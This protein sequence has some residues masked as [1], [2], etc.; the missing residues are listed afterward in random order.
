MRFQERFLPYVLAIASSAIALLLKLSLEPILLHTI[1]EFFYIAIVITAWYSGGRA[2]FVTLVLATLAINYFFLPPIYKFG[3]VQPIDLVQLGIF[4]LVG[5]TVNLVSSNFRDSKRKI[6]QL[7]QQLIQEKAD[8]LRIAPLAAQMGMWNWDIVTGKNQWSPDQEQL[9]GL[10]PGT[11]DG[12]YETFLSYIHPED[13]ERVNQ[14]LQQ[15]IQNHS[16]Y[17]AEFRI[18]WAD[19]S[20]HWIEARGHAFYNQAGE[21]IQMTGTAT[22]IDQR[23][24]AQGLLQDKF[25]Q[26][27]LVMEVTQRIRQSLNLQDIFQNTVDEIRQL[28]QTDRVI[29]FQFDPQWRGT[30]VA[31]SVGTDWTATLSTEIYNPCFSEQYVEPYKQGLVTVKSDIYNVGID[32][33]HLQ[34]LANFQV[35]ANLVVPIVKEGELWGLL[36]AHHCAAPR[37]WQSSEINLMQQ[38]ASQVSIAI[39][40]SQ[41]FEQV[42]TELAERR[43]AEAL[44]RLFIQYAP[45][46]IAMLDRD[47]RYLMASQ[48]WVDQHNLESVE[49]LIGR[50]H[51]EIFPEIPERWRQIH[52]RC[53]AG[54]IEKSEEDLFIRVNG[55]KIWISWEIHPW[56]TAKDEIGGIIIFSVDIS[57]LKNTKIALQETQTQLQQQ[58]AE[59][60]S[61]YQSVP[62]GLAV[63]DIELRYTRINQRL[64][65]INGVSVETHIGRTVREV[66]PNVADTAEQLLRS[67]LETGEALLNVEIVGETPAQPG[68][69]RTWIESWLPLKNDE[70]IIGISVV[71]EE[72]TARKQAEMA[73]QQ[74][75][76]ELE[77]RIT[78]RTAEVSFVNDRLL[79]ALMALQ[80]SEER[81]R[82]SLDLTNV[83]F[84]DMQLP[85]KE[86]I[87]NENH[88]T[89]LGLDPS[90]EPSYE[91]W[92]SHIHPEDRSWVE[93]QFLESIENRT[94][95]TAEYR[96]VYPDNSVHWV[97]ARGKAV[98][99]KSGQPLRALG[100]LLDISDRKRAKQ[101]LELQAVITRNMAE[102][103]CLVRADDGTI[104]YANPKFEQMFGY[105]SGELNG[106]HVSIVNYS[107]EEVTAEDVNQA[108]RSAIFQSSEATYEVH[109]LKKDGTPFWCRATCSV[110]KHPDYGDVLVTVHQDITTAKHLQQEREQAEEALRQSEARFR[111]LSQYSPIGVFMTDIHGQCI[112]TNRHYQA[113]CGCTFEELLG[114]GYIQFIHPEDRKKVLAQWSQAISQ[115]QEFSGEFRYINKQGTI[116][117]VRVQSASILTDSDEL[118][119][120]VGTVDDIT[121][122]R[123]IEQ[124]KSEFISIVSHEL[125][126]PLASIR[127]SMGLLAS[128]VLKNKP[129]TAQQML[130]IAVHDTER[131]VRLVNDILDLERLEANKIN[132]NKQW[133]DALTLMRRSVENLESLALQSNITL[134]VEPTSIQV[135][136]DSDR[137]IQT[138][139]NL[140]GNAIKFSPPQSTITLNVQDQAEQVLFQVKDQGRGIPADKLETIF[141][142][143]QQ[144]DASDS[145]QKGGTGLGLAICKTIVQQHGGK[146][147]VESVVGEGS[148]FYFTLTK[149]FD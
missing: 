84:W 136:A 4:F 63:L 46:G 22:A 70:H 85:N 48:R 132:L 89:L 54:A 111:S 26:Q 37:Q 74:L 16:L 124:M 7:N 133:C 114:E 102:G 96:V 28:L 77:T 142:R 52:Q 41:L 143:F 101:M 19:G 34:L 82:L 2:G 1:N 14:A 64:A 9:F 108:I 148:S 88:F 146:I 62:I 116:R 33:C 135:W 47:M 145:R 87:W 118:V 121:K 125:R 20:I 97:M 127:G 39:Q 72:I 117:F 45:A 50:S 106:Q 60:E 140:I 24:Q 69:Q 35:R 51:Y 129:E 73:L 13:R 138:L 32:P 75:N 128:G 126:T 3:Y 61:I 76:A 25:E 123:I 94:D 42:Q 58:L 78:E 107:S 104:V 40:Q 56:Y 31:E 5:L 27:R 81:R 112:Y 44:L 6:E 119:G 130:D 122:T 65:D 36:I 21:P 68:V 30:V 79:E 12:K 10:I 134:S 8:L 99:D 57:N 15:A 71:C 55:S 59:I 67:I 120:Y 137:I 29:I 113:I 53:L 93:Q 95:Y 110:F 80:T 103:I 92:S 38:L 144:V 17:Q 86:I 66:V 11:F 109:N 43:Q 131:L 91:L 98:Y 147:W 115:Q 18:V 23:K 105:N 90:L 139:V 149:F 100:V 49:S 83:G 141:G